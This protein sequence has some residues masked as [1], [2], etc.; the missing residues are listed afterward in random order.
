MERLD[1]NLRHLR[2]FLAIMESGSVT[3]AAREVHL[4]QPAVTQGI[5]KLELRFGVPLFERQPRR[6]I[7]T[8]EA[9]IL[10]PRATAII[11]L[12]GQT[13][14]TAAQVSAFLGLSRAGSYANA[15]TAMGLSEASLHRAVSDLSLALGQD[16]VRRRGKGVV[17]TAR[18]LAMARNFRLALAELRSA[19]IELAALRGHERG[20]ITIGAMPLSRARL[21]PSAVA[22]FHR[23]KPDIDIVI[24]EGSY[25]ELTGPLRDGDIDMM[26]GAARTNISADMAQR[27]LFDDPLIILA[28]AHH[29]LAQAR[30]PPTIAALARYPW[31]VAA[32]GTP[33][34]AHWQSMFD[35]AGVTPPRVPME[36]GSVMIVRQILVES[37]FL[38]LLSPDQVSVELEAG[39]LVRIAGP[40]RP[41]SRTI[42]LTVRSDWRPTPAQAALIE[43]IEEQAAVLRDEHTS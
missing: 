30:Q 17:L 10:A 34:R 1:V 19:D 18:G 6:M 35:E 21:L 4:T 28:G 36:C 40:V 33:L 2:A 37:D 43:V 20:R 8:D 39:W 3:A 5:A 42:G 16:L 14:A 15:A 32:A 12:L 25:A 27:E 9:R 11:R 26:V 13:R 22:A 38:T 41:M 29:P 7:P 31:I 23:A 24:M